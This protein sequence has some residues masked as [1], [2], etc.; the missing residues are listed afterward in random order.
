[1]SRDR[2]WYES[3]ASLPDRD[4]SLL[5]AATVL[6]LR[7][8]PS[9]PEVLLV[10]HA[11][12]DRFVSGVWAFPG[13]Q[14]EDVDTRGETNRF[15]PSVGRNAAA[16]ETAEEVDLVV[17]P[18]SLEAWSL[19][20]PPSSAPKRYSTW[21]FVADAPAGMAEPDGA[22]ITDHVWAT[23]AEAF[24]RRDAGEIR[25]LPPTYLS[26][27]DLARHRDVASVLAAARTREPPTYRTN[28]V[29]ITE[30]AVAMWEGDAGWES[31]DIEMPGPRHRLWMRDAAW[32][33]E[34]S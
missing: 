4:P 23:P 32:H 5:P 19:W 28:L 3:W 17:E 33:L 22:E 26:L 14:V 21:F 8:G 10:R 20:I 15:S 9:G 13:G 16:R 6:L 29:M 24:A 18:Q 2:D 30:G 34:I 11:R 1:M 27:F 7:D 31:G 25:L 12:S